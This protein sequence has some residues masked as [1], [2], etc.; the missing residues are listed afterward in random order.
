MAEKTIHYSDYLQLN[1]ILSAQNRKSEE[2]G[3]PAHDEMLF[4]TIHQ[5]YELWFKQIIFE[6]DSVI[7]LFKVGKIDESNIGTVLS[8]FERINMIH[9][10]LLEQLPIIETMPPMN[11]LEFRD[12][13]VPA[14]GFQSVQFRLL[15]NKLGLRLKRRVQFDKTAY[16][17]QGNKAETSKLEH[18]E[19]EEPLFSL[20]EK[21]LERIPF[22]KFE[23]FDFLSSYRIA[24]DKMLTH[25]EQI[26]KN[27]PNL[28]EDGKKNQLKAH[29]LTKENFEALFD[30]K[31]YEKIRADGR[32]RLSYKATIAA[33]LIFL[34]RDEPILHIPFKILTGLIDCDELMT[35]WRYRHALMA[36]RMIGSK[37]GTGGSSGFEYLKQAAESHKI[38]SDFANLSTFMIPRSAL[39][40]L[41][42]DLKKNLGFFYGS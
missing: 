14:S 19:E 22:L 37:I 33:L 41:P 29:N 2:V 28:S 16:Y 32:V 39:P 4:I 1:K 6:L 31:L 15:E 25:E 40:N 27:N 9:N 17:Q 10:L 3:R 7:D 42:D 35:L 18:S 23:K 5:A 24:V 38:F 12:L 36:H 34:Y 26:I 21:W 13:L 8:R 11:F 30:E 20:I